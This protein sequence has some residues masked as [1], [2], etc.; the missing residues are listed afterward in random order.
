LVRI[1]EPHIFDLSTTTKTKQMKNIFAPIVLDT[2]VPTAES[3]DKAFKLG[4]ESRKDGLTSIIQNSSFLD[5]LNL[6]GGH[7]EPLVAGFNKG[8]RS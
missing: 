5:L 6:H 7:I 1:Y 3:I 2:Q 8:Y 4:S